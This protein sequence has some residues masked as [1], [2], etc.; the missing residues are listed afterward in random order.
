MLRNWS[1]LPH[2]M[3]IASNLFRP[4]EHECEDLNCS[5]FY[6]MLPNLWIIKLIPFSNE[7]NLF[8]YEIST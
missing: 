1:I 2:L 5:H 3:I 4:I 7:N 6:D 8:M